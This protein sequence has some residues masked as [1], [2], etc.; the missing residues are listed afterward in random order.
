M[1]RVFSG[2][3]L[4]GVVPRVAPLGSSTALPPGRFNV[5][6]VLY[7]LETLSFVAH[8][9]ENSQ[10]DE[11]KYGRYSDR[12]VNVEHLDFVGQHVRAGR[13]FASPHIDKV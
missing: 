6:L 11:H 4:L 9:T 3:A 10:Q 5:L 1:P 12:N 7:A 13:R 8:V 2:F